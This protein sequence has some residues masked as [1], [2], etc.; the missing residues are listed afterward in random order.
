MFRIALA[1][2]LTSATLFAQTGEKEI[3]KKIPIGVPPTQMSGGQS[4]RPSKPIPTKLAKGFKYVVHWTGP[5]V[6]DAFSPD[7]GDVDIK[8]Y[9]GP[10]PFSTHNTISDQKPD[11]DNEDVVT[12]T[13]KH[14]YVVTAKSPGVVFLAVFP[15]LGRVGADA[16]PIPLT[17]DDIVRRTLAVQLDPIPPPGPVDPDPPTP[18]PAGIL[19]EGALPADVESTIALVKKYDASK[20]LRILIVEEQSERKKLPPQQLAIMFSKTLAEYMDKVTTTDKNSKGDETPAWRIFD[21]D[22]STTNAA[23]PW[24]TLMSRPRQS[25]PWIIIANEGK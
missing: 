4:V 10:R 6:V 1:L 2:F 12:I 9:A 23:T 7:A 22:T 5:L 20:G 14:I 24:K 3:T 11:A 17:R 16:T 15:A 18:L 8:E 25:L 19:F 13:D 21:K